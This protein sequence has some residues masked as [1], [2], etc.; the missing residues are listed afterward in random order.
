MFHWLQHKHWDSLGLR[1][2]P[3]HGECNFRTAPFRFKE[4]SNGGAH[5]GPVLKVGAAD[6]KAVSCPTL[7]RRQVVPFV[8]VSRQAIALNGWV[9]HKAF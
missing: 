5:S 4:N 2:Y 9:V 3:C 7:R 1:Q 6:L 8:G